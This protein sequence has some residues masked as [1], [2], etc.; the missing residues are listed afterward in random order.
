MFRKVIGFDGD[1]KT[2]PAIWRIGEQGSYRVNGSSSGVRVFA[3][4]ILGDKAVRY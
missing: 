1:G 3:W 4:G 2:D